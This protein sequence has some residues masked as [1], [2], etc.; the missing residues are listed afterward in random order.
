MTKLL[1][2][3]PINPLVPASQNAT[4]A[5][6]ADLKAIDGDYPALIRSKRNFEIAHLKQGLANLEC[7]ILVG[8]CHIRSPALNR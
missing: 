3:L 4:K 1:S 5:V 6:L 2:Q 7:W 8:H